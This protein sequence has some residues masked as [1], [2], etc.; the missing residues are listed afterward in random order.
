MVASGLK[1]AGNASLRRSLVASLKK[2]GGA[3]AE[4]R[5]GESLTRCNKDFPFSQ[6]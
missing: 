2:K 4:E 6:D 5:N 1:C 3:G